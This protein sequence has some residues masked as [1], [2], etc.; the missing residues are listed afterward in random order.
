[1]MFNQSDITFD[2]GDVITPKF[3]DE[4]KNLGTDI[5]YLD[6]QISSLQKHIVT[7]ESTILSIEQALNNK[8]NQNNPN[9]D[10]NKLYGI[11]NKTLKRRIKLYAW[12][13]H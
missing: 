5:S 4:T 12:H 13:R 3:I 9:F 2:D 7:L 1:M 10:R 11:L 8:N 6:M